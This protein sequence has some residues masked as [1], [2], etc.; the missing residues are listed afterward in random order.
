MKSDK[1]KVKDYIFAKGKRK[2]A[3]AR[4]RLF[5]TSKDVLFGEEKLK[6]GEI[7]VNGKKIADYFSGA[8]SKAIYTQPFSSTNTLEKFIATIKVEGGGLEGQLDAVVHG[9]SR[10]ISSI[11]PKYRG[12]LK[13]QGFLTR[14][15]RVRERR[16]VG[17]GGKARRRKQSPKR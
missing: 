17:M 6:K 2:S 13:K 8:V 9:L 14:D 5:A 1:T 4:I 16:K 7:V 11:D 3:V 12:I 10:A 15:A